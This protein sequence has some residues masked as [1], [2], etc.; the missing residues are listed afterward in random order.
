M[1][2][3]DKIFKSD[4]ALVDSGTSCLTIPADVIED[5]MEEF[6]TNYGIK[7]KFKQEHY[8]PAY[9]LVHFFF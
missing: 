8:A 2:I 3:G 4:V 9:S 7:Y 1:G 6:E 5:I